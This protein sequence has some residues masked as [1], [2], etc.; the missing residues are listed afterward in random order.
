MTDTSQ[1]PGMPPAIGQYELLARIGSGGSG[2]VFKARHARLRS[3]VALKVLSE[4]RTSEAVERFHREMA[5]VGQ[6]HHPNIVRATDAGEASGCYFLAMEYVDGADVWRVLRRAG[7]LAIP[8]ACEIARQAAEA[9][10]FIHRN[11]M[12]HRDIKPSNM[13]LGTDGVVRLLDLGLARLGPASEPLT[14]A[15]AVMGTADF[16]APEQARESHDVDIRADVYSLGCTLYALLAGEPPFGGPEFDSAYKKFRAHNEE[17]VPPLQDR[18]ADVPRGLA[19]LIEWM[20]EKEPF[21]R[22]GTPAEAAALL[23]PF[24]AG[25]HLTALAAGA[26]PEAADETP[27]SPGRTPT[28]LPPLRSTAEYVAEPSQAPSSLP[29]RPVGVITATAVA[30]ATALL[31][32][33]M[34]KPWVAPGSPAI[35]ATPDLNTL[36]APVSG[37]EVAP[38]P[39]LAPPPRKFVPGQWCELL[40]RLPQEYFWSAQST[41][42]KWVF[43][44]GQKP[45]LAIVNGPDYGLLELATLPEQAY[46]LEVEVDQHPWVG[47]V[48]VFV[49]GRP[50]IVDGR[51]VPT[52]DFVCIYPIDARLPGPQ[53]LIGR[54]IFRILYSGRWP[55]YHEPVP[56]ARK[57]GVMRHRIGLTVTVAGITEIRWDGDPVAQD[58]IALQVGEELRPGAAGAVGVMVRRRSVVFHSFKVRLHPNPGATP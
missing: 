36:V 18:R 57:L 47:G 9:L 30:S 3:I 2:T 23:A 27:V 22:L 51:P 28:A 20:L 46:D 45:S 16:I 40:D 48:G 13:L 53:D 58:R 1:I 54:G 52:A 41:D 39:R 8:D 34:W 32:L 11:G 37:A 26:M 10:A 7:R 4:H 44:G 42:A 49:R 21:N 24:C 14:G 31:A 5:A 12:V 25:H 15:G 35:A 6:L 29:R 55:H 19:E 38:P 17:P 50:E 43:E 33:L 56:F